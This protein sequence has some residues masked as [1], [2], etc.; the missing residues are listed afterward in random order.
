MKG[1]V[2]SMTTS[3]LREVMSH[4]EYVVN[5]T[6]EAYGCNATVTW[7]PDFYPPTDNDYNLYNNIGKRVAEQ[8]GAV[9]EIQPSMGAEDFSFISKEV[10]SLFLLLGQGGMVGEEK[11]TSPFG[12]TS[13]GLHHP[14]FTV[15]ERVL[16][17]GVQLHVRLA[18]ESLRELWEEKNRK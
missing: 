14:K 2:R 11:D 15:D 8:V 13:W 18:L 16:V 6:A 7:S 9:K 1:T 4:V 10:P 3:G 12:D 5:Q 17:K